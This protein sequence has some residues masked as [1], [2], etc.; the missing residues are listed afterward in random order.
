MLIALP[1]TVISGNFAT[2]Y[3]EQ[4]IIRMEEQEKQA[5]AKLKKRNV[6]EDAQLKTPRDAF[7]RDKRAV[8]ASIQHDEKEDEEVVVASA[9]TTVLNRGV[10]SDDGS[11]TIVAD[12]PS[13]AAMVIVRVCMFASCSL[14]LSLCVRAYVPNVCI[15]S[16]AGVCN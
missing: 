12:I 9:A 6:I 14:S 13:H 1:I 4:E 15:C 7:S 3:A 10:L 11:H 5:Q 2:I 8:I 16:H